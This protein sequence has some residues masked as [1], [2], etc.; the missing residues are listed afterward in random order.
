MFTGRF[1]RNEARFIM[2][3]FRFCFVDDHFGLGPTHGDELEGK[4]RILGNPQSRD[5]PPQYG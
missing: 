2:Q 1:T 3:W 5:I 4:L